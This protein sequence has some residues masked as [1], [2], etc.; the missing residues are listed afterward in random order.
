MHF[1]LTLTDGTVAENSFHDEPMQFTV[2]DGTMIEGLESLL[3]GLKA[4]DR[5]RVTIN[6]A[7][8]FGDPSEENVHNLPRSEFSEELQLEPDLVVAFTTPSG[9]EIPGTILEVSNDEVKV[10]FNHPLA[11][12]E[13]I[14]E[15]EIIDVK[16]P[17]TMLH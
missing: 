3:Y 5:K 2:G 9:E 7:D 14:F 6:P 17:Q 8:A 15:F 12:H 16:A 4:G 1:S 11:G 13:L 10:D